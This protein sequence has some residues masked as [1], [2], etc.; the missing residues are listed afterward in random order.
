VQANAYHVAEAGGMVWVHLAPGLPP[1]VPDYQWM[2]VPDEN[3][4]IVPVDLDCNYV[5]PLE[6]LADSSHVGVLH[7]DIVRVLAEASRSDGAALAT[8]QA[9]RLVVE[10]TDFGF[11]YAALRRVPPPAAGHQVRVTAYVAPWLFL[12]APGGQAFMAVPQDDTHTRFYNIFW[13]PQRRLLDGPG[14]EERLTTFG[15]HPEQLRAVGLLVTN[16]STGDLGDRNRFTQDRDAMRT[17]QTFTGLPGLTAEDAAMTSSMGPMFDRANEHLVPSDLAV[18][19]LRRTLLALARTQTDGHRSEPA[20]GSETRT[21]TA[22]SGTITTD[23]DWHDL[24]PQHVVTGS[25]E[26]DDAVQVS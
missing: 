17:R 10:D 12:I 22:A 18:I 19:R 24:V 4:L 26:L 14:R 20:E 1:P 8:D 15:L 21:I 9:P 5:Q 7:N 2:H 25:A 16:P 6:G 23:A 3:L 11:H 13:D